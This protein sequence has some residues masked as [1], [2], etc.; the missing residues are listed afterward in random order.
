[1]TD[2]VHHKELRRSGGM[3]FPSFTQSV[4]IKDLYLNNCYLNFWENWFR[5]TTRTPCSNWFLHFSIQKRPNIHDRKLISQTSSVK[6][7]D[8]TGTV[9]VKFD[10]NCTTCDILM[11]FGR[12]LA[13]CV[14][15][16]FNHGFSHVYVFARPRH[17]SMADHIWSV[18][19]LNTA[20][21]HC[22]WKEGCYYWPVSLCN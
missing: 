20:L 12:L 14:D 16:W 9:E 11:N 2:F 1:M 13:T 3:Y 19:H 15:T 8:R 21:L 4:R 5:E 6:A 7:I 10:N 22:H 18:L 17:I